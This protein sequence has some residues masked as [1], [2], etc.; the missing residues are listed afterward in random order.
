M[1]LTW[2]VVHFKAAK[3]GLYFTVFIHFVWYTDL[4]ND[5][6]CKNGFT[7]SGRSGLCFI[8]LKRRLCMG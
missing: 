6:I 5:P 4:L 1:K 2:M 7:P 8:K 3:Y